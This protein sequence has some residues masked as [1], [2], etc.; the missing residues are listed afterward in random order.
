[1]SAAIFLFNAGVIE[2]VARR[3]N[4]RKLDVLKLK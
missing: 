3:D 4:H 1:V 2:M